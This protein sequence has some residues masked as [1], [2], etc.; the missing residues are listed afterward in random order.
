M[1][2]W[3]TNV[4]SYPATSPSG[5]RTCSG[6]AFENKNKHMGTYKK[7]PRCIRHYFRVTEKEEIQIRRDMANAD[8]LSQSKYFRDMI[9]KRK[10]SLEKVCVTDRTTRNQIN[11]LSAKIE[12]IGINYNQAVRAL[13]SALNAKVVK[14]KAAA[15]YLSLLASLSDEIIKRQEEIIDRV[16]EMGSHPVNIT[17][18]QS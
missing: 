9:L 1:G 10:I 11:D 18:V 6:V 5:G 13:H 3:R 4:L 15:Y 16:S 17:F 8:Y 7:E 14:G 2:R 12:R